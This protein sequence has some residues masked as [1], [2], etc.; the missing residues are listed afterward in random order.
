MSRRT[1]PHALAPWSRRSFLRSTVVG[2][3]ALALGG[4]A[5]AQAPMAERR[6]VL[7][8]LRGGMDGLATV[9]P[10]GDPDFSRVRSRL[11]P[12]PTTDAEEMVALDG[13]FALHPALSSLGPLVEAGELA[14]VHAVA[15]PYRDR[16]HFDVQEVLE[17]GTG[18]PGGARDGWLNR[19]LGGTVGGP[20]MA[21]VAIGRG[22]PLVLRGSHEVTSVD[23]TGVNITHDPFV[24]EV[25]ALWDDDP[26]LHSGL[27]QGIAARELTGGE[28][29]EG[30]KRSR[31]RDGALSA[32]ATGVGAVLVQGPQVAVIELSGWDTHASQDRALARSL[33]GLGTG[34]IALRA[35]LGDTWQHTVVCCVSEFGRTVAPNGTGGTDHGTAGAVLLAGGAVAGG[36][37]HGT[38][39]GLAEADRLDGRDLRPTTDVRAVFKGLLEDHLG[40]PRAAVARAFPD[41]AK[42]SALPDLVRG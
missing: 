36:R 31:R 33:D 2:S 26:L 19:A 1:P 18:A 22:V 30:Q 23:P 7:V 41:S 6:F 40:L 11:G 15:T 20:A 21:G 27:A 29:G 5:R 32:M 37:V 3:A 14:A 38:W 24:Q 35:A 12:E 4:R 42:V 13:D 10:T 28:E 34:I 8:I 9:V 16:S 25:A 17:N 39:P